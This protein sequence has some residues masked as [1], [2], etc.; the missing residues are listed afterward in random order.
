MTRAD[1]TLKQLFYSTQSVHLY[2]YVLPVYGQI[3]DKETSQIR[4]MIVSHSV[5]A[6]ESYH[7]PISPAK[8]DAF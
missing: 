7:S 2:I 1:L 8:R 3:F 4:S 5:A 6:F